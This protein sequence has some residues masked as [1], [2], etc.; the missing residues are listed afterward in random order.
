MTSIFFFAYIAAMLGWVSRSYYEVWR[1]KQAE[2]SVWRENLA[3]LEQMQQRA[4]QQGRMFMLDDLQ[5][6][7]APYRSALPGK[8]QKPQLRR[9][10]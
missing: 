6:I 3:R 9:V 10:K 8:T 7:A 2:R 4:M 5:D 1:A